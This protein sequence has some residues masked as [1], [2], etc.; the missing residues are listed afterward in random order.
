LSLDVFASAFSRDRDHPC[1]ATSA[2]KT[3]PLVVV[4]VTY[5]HGHVFVGPLTQLFG[6]SLTTTRLTAVSRMRK[7]G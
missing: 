5:D 1:T 2:A 3:V 6:G 4:T 7:E